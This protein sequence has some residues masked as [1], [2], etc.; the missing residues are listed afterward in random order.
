MMSR[1][2]SSVEGFAIFAVADRRSISIYRHSLANN[3]PVIFMYRFLLLGIVSRLTA[4]VRLASYEIS[5][6]R[7]SSDGDDKLYLYPVAREEGKRGRSILLR[8]VR[9]ACHLFYDQLRRI[10]KLAQTSLENRPI[11]PFRLLFSR[12]RSIFKLVAR[13]DRY[14]RPSP[15]SFLFYPPEISHDHRHGQFYSS[16][17]GQVVCR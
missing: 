3:E 17:R 5:F 12:E 16:E 14:N 15:A 8:I 4:E 13:R 1:G 11:Q 10:T 6:Y 7:Y 2:D 9:T